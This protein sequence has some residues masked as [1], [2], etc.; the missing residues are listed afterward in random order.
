[1]KSKTGLKVLCI[2][3]FVW[4]IYCSNLCVHGESEKRG[5]GEAEGGRQ[6]GGERGREGEGD[7][8]ARYLVPSFVFK[9]ANNL[10]TF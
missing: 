8:V 5:G 3:A 2:F 10:S 7:L 9:I 6:K 4:H 1:M